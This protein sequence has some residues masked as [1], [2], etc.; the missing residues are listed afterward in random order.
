MCNRK[1]SLGFSLL[2]KLSSSPANLNR[3]NGK[4]SKIKKKIHNIFNKI[5]GKRYAR[6]PLNN[7]KCLKTYSISQMTQ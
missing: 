7:S 6:S 2:K 4:I 1:S 3:A 5:N